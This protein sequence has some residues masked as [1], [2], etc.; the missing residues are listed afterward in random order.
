MT[1]RSKI[2]RGIA[3]LLCVAGLAALFVTAAAAAPKSAFAPKA[4]SYSGTVAT[5]GNNSH[6][7]ALVVKKGASYSVVESIPF[8]ST[9]ETKYGPVF[10]PLQTPDLKMPVK[11]KA[12]TYTGEVPTGG[13]GLGKMK[14]KIKGHFT[15]ASAFTATATA[16]VPYEAGNPEAPKCPVPSVTVKMK[17]G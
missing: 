3:V 2:H 7:S 11:G 1:S 4:G 10:T 15:S 12:F 16:E 13:S 5:E 17:V 14:V 9:C 8:G 6:G